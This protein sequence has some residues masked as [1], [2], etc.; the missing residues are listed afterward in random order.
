MNFVDTYWANMIRIIAEP[1]EKTRL[2]VLELI[3]KT[4]DLWSLVKLADSLHEAEV[5]EDRIKCLF[6]VEIGSNCWKE[7]LGCDFR[8]LVEIHFI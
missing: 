4:E 2:G 7:D 5:P 8:A 6:A 3:G 1:E